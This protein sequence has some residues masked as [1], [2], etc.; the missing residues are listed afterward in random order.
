MKPDY[1]LTAWNHRHKQVSKINRKT[2]RLPLFHN[3]LRRFDT[4]AM[5]IVLRTFL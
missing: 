3:N 1:S 2:K 4:I 5:R